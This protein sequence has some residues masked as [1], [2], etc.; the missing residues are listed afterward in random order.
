MFKVYESVLWNPPTRSFGLWKTK[1]IFYE[2]TYHK[3]SCITNFLSFRFRNLCFV[4]TL[5]FAES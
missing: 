4:H 3:L 2:Y 5:E 1:Q